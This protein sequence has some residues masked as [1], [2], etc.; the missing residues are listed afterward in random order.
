MQLELTE[1]Q[2]DCLSLGLFS[3]FRTNPDFLTLL[4]EDTEH[5]Y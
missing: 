1:R 3:M 2:V 5:D 4:V